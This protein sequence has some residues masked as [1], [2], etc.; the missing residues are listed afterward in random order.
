VSKNK[1]GKENRGRRRRKE[2]KGEGKRW[3]LKQYIV[4]ALDKTKPSRTLPFACSIDFSVT[5]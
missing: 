1:K 2:E 3:K 5:F 4:R